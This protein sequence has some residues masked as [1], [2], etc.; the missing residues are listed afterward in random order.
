MRDM[1][2]HFSLSLTLAKMYSPRPGPPITYEH[3]PHPPISIHTHFNPYFE[4]IV[5]YLESRSKSRPFVDADGRRNLWDTVLRR[6]LRLKQSRCMKQQSQTA[7]SAPELEY[8]TVTGIY[9]IQLRISDFYSAMGLVITDTDPYPYTGR[10][11]R[12]EKDEIHLKMLA[13]YTR[14]IDIAAQAHFNAHGDHIPSTACIM[15]MKNPTPIPNQPA[16]PILSTSGPDPG[17]GT[18]AQH[19]IP[20]AVFP[21]LSGLLKNEALKIQKQNLQGFLDGLQFLGMSPQELRGFEVHFGH[22]AEALAL[23][24]MFDPEAVRCYLHGIA[25]DVAPIRGMTSYNPQHFRMRLK[26][27]CLNCQYVIRVLNDAKGSQRA[28]GEL[29]FTYSDR[30]EPNPDQ[31]RHTVVPNSVKCFRYKCNNTS[32]RS[33]E[34][35]YCRTAWYCSKTC[36]DS[37]WKYHGHGCA[38]FKR[39]AKCLL[40]QA[41]RACQGCL[42]VGRIPARYC[43]D[44]HRLEDWPSHQQW[45]QDLRNNGPPPQL[46]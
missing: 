6:T 17:T 43:T 27:A 1:K 25:T 28:G 13:T 12:N 11:S 36:R 18:P 14:W 20:A 10:E 31:R 40:P 30:A 38:R 22:C 35:P 44:A 7:N 15:Y 45:C 26:K 39:C 23:L 3:P 2:R 16:A 37:D 29:P 32:V 42:R 33:E 41:D 34:C 9:G 5:H 19:F 24:Y 8:I 21:S 4:Q 46:W